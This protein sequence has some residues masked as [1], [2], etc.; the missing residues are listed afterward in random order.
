MKAGWGNAN[1]D[2][3][4][5]PHFDE[6]GFKRSELKELADKLGI[7]LS[8]PLEDVIPTS[9][10]SAESKPMSDA[11]IEMLRMEIDTL[12][13]QVRKLESERP[14]L[15]KKYRE[16]DPLYL[17][18]QIRNQ[19]WLK[20]DHDNDRATRGNQTAIIKELEDSGFSN[21]QAKAIELVACP[22]KR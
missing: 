10:I 4:S 2:H 21:I 11:D 15:I 19:E 3:W 16:D 12:R 7:D 18:I 9:S 13:R 17:A 1:Q 6:Y 14:I 22:I 5:A 8:V 20:Y